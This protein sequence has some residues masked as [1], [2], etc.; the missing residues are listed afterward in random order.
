MN[1][2]FLRT[3]FPSLSGFLGFSKSLNETWRVSYHGNALRLTICGHLVLITV[4]IRLITEVKVLKQTDY[5][6]VAS[7]IQSSVEKVV[8]A[9]WDMKYP[10]FYG[11]TRFM[12]V[13][14]TACYWSRTWASWMRLASWHSVYLRSAV[15][16]SFLLRLDISDRVLSLGFLTQILHTF[17]MCPMHA[18]GVPSP[19][20]GGMKMSKFLH[21][22]FLHP[23]VICPNIFL[24]TLFWKTLRSCNRVNHFTVEAGID[25]KLQGH[26]R[27]SLPRIY[28]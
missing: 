11:S 18:D 19:L 21:M 7:P 6:S 2:S 26:G 15:I 3:L 10:V 24:S 9:Q 22:L 4:F 16:L 14:V 5:R 20:F 1:W 25:C 27:T 17:L 23:P 28:F 13:F 12:T 8:P